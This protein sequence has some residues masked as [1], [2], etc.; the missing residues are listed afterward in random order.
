MQVFGLKRW[1]SLLLA[2]IMIFSVLPF[3]ALAEEEHDH[4]HSHEEEIQSSEPAVTE[5]EVT[6]PSETPTETEPEVTEPEVTEPEAAAEPSAQA[7]ELVN[8]I[9]AV[10][11]TFGVTADMDDQQIKQAIY[12]QPWSV[13][14]PT[15]SQIAQIEALAEEVPE[16]DKDYV[17]ANADV[18]TYVRFAEI[19]KPMFVVMKAS[20]AGDHTPVTGVTVGVSGA[21]DNSMSNGAVTVTAKGS[22][23]ILGFGASAKTATITV[24]NESG[25]TAKISFDW[26]ATSV[27]QLKIDGTVYSG[28]TSGKFEKT[29]DAGEKFIITIT[30]AKNSTVNKLVMSNFVCQIAKDSSSVT[31]QYDNT[32]GSITVAGNAVASGDSLDISSAGAAVVATP[33]NGAAFLGWIDGNHT[34][35]SKD[36]TFTLQPTE[37]MT[38][39]AV[40]AKNAWFLVNGNTLYE[41]LD[42]A[43][44]AVASVSNKTIV[45]ANNGT[46]PAGDYTIPSGVTLLIP[47]DANNTLYTTVPGKQEEAYAAP[48]VYRTLTMA[49]DAKIVVNGAMSIAAVQCSAGGL[50]SPTGPTGFVQ[51][52][53]G[54]NITVNNGGKLYAWG[55]IQGQGAVTVESGG[56]VYECFQ[57]MDWRGG[58][59]T[60]GMIDN[61]QEVFPFTQYYVQNVEVPMKLKA[62]AIENGYMSV[63]ITLAGIQGSEV[64][65]IGSD[66]MFNI[67]DGYIIKDYDEGTGRL[68][69]DIYGNISVKSLSITMKISVLGA[70]TIN[71]KNYDLPINGNMTITMHSGAVTM[72]QDIALLPGAK[73][74]VES[75]AICTLGEGNKIFVYDY[76]EW[77]TA[78]DPA[79][80]KGPS[81]CGTPDATHINLKYPASAT[82]VVG[83]TDDACVIVNGKADLSAGFAYTTSGGANITSTGSGT[84]K[85][86]PGQETVTYQVKCTGSD[87]KNVE[88]IPI[89]IT[90]A[91][92]K[93]ADGSYTLTEDDT[94]DKLYTYKYVNGEWINDCT[95][96][97]RTEIP[98]VKPTCTTAGKTVGEKCSGCGTVT[99]QQ[100]DIEALGHDEQT[101]E[102]KAPTCT[103]TGWD[104]YVTCSRCD[105]STKVEKAAL[106]HDEVEHDAKAPTCTEIGWEAY[107]TC[108]R[109]DYT[110]YAEKAALGHT[111]GAEAT[112]TTNQVCTVCGAELKAAL[113]HAIVSHEAQAPTCTEVGWEAYVTCSRCDYTTYAEKAALDHDMIVDTG[114]AATCTEPGYQSG[115][116]CSRCDYTEGGGVIAALGHTAGAEAT[117]TAAQICTVCNAELKA[118]LGHDEVEHDAKAPTCTE[119]GWDAYETCSRCDYTTYAEKA[120]LGHDEIKHDAK[121]PTCT[122]IGWDA[123]VT[124]SRCNYTTYAEKAALGHDEIKH[125][126]KAPT[127]TEIGWDAY[128]TCSRCN[129]TTYVEKAALDHAIVSHE[130][131]APTC[132]EVGWDAYEACSRC[133]Y[134]T[135]VEKAALGH[136]EVEH[137][138]QAPTC[139][140]IGWDAYVTCTRCDHT[141]YEEKDALG[142]DEVSHEAQ[143]PTCTEIGWDAYVTCSRCNYTTYVPKAALGHDRVSHAAK[144]AT[145]TEIGWQA[146]VTCS[147]CDFTTYK[148]IKAKGHTAGAEATCTEAQ[149]CTVCGAELNA[150]LG[151]DMIIDEK[152][153]ATCTTPGSQAGAHCSR[154]DYTEGGGVIAA[155]GHTPGAEA[156]CTAAQICTVCNAELKAALGHDKETHN[157]KAPTCEDIGWDAY[158]TCSRCDYST[159]VEKAALGHDEVEHD[160]KA[161]TCTE[162][163]W[164][165]YVT[166]SRCDYSTYAEKAALGHDEVEHDA[167]AP[168]C[169]E[170]GWDAYVTCSRCDYSTY[171]E[172]AALGHDEVGHGAKAPTCTAIGWDAYE[173]CS[174]CDYTTYAEKAALG[175]DEVE[176]EAK[177]PTCTEIGWDAYVTC[178]RCDY[179]T[180]AEKAALQHDEIKHDAKAPTCTEIG[181]DAYV[182][183]SRCDYTTYAEKAALD[184]A[185]VKHEAQAPT[186]TEIGWDAYETCSRC[187]YTTYAEKAALGHDEVEHEAQAP[188]CTAFGWDAYV[189]CTRC[190][191]TTYQTKS[192]LGHDEV[193]VAAQAPTCTEV[194]WDAYEACSRCDYSTKVEKAALGHDRVQ[195]DAKNATCTE[196]G[197]QA[198]VTCTRCDLN[199]YKEIS[200]KGHDKKT[201]E[202]KAPT[203]TE[204]GWDAY[205]T[206]SRCDYS[207]YAEKASLGHDEV[208]HDAKAPTCT[209]IGWESFVTCSRCDYTTYAEKAA[210]GHDEVEHDAKAPTCTEIGWDAYVTCSRC[211]YT[212]YAEKAAL[213]HAIVSHDAKAPTCTEIGWDAYEACSRCDYT[214]YVEK[215]AL[216]HTDGAEATCTTNQVC[217]VCGAELKAALGHDM[218]RDNEVPA[219]CTTPGHQ[220][221]AH[222]SRCDYTEGGGEIPALGHTEVIDKAVAPDCENTGLTEG[223]HC[224]VCEKVL[225]AQEVV[226]ALGHTEVIDKAVA[227]DCENTGLT[228]GKHCSVCE[229]ILV[230]QETVKALGHDEVEHDAKAPT[231]TE[232]GW[233]AYETCSRCDYTTYAEKA[234]LGHDEVEHEA[235]APTC[236]EI[237]WDAYVTCSRCDYTTYAEKAALGHDEVAHEA[238]APTCTEIGWEA[239]VTCSR[240]DYTTY[241]EKTALGHDEVEHD[242]KAPTCTEI[243]WDAY[244]TCSRCDYTTYVAKDAL[245]HDKVSHEAQAPTC[246]EIGWKAYVTCTR[247]N[248]T[249]YIEEAA[250]GHDRVSHDAKNPTCTEIGWQAYVTCSRCDFTTY[251]EIKAKGHTAGAEATCT[252]AQICTV[253]KEELKA[254]LGHDEVEHEAKAPTCTEIGWDAYVTCSR[255]DYSTYA[256]KAALKHDEVEHEAKAPTCTEI[257][258]DAYV[259]CSRCDYST[260]AEKA[261]LGHDEEA[262]NAKAPTCTAIGW[263]AY[264]TC[265]RCDYTTYAEK[266]ALGHDEVEHEAQAPTCTEIGWDAY[267]TCSRCDYTT[268]AEKAALGHD[269]VE[270]DAKAPT[271]TEIGWNAYVTCSRC[272]YSTYAEKAA[273]GHDEVGHGAKAPTCTSIGW[274]AYETC[275]RCDYTTYVEKAALGHD[276]VEHEAKAPTCTE[277]GWDAYV[278]CSRCD[279]STYAEK[280]ALKHDEIK[281]DAKAPTCTEIGWNAYVTCSRCDYTTYAEKAALNHAIVKHEAQAPTCTEIGWDAYETCS[282]CDYTTYAQKAA[283][284]HDEVEHEAQAPTCTAIGWDAYETC[285]RCDYTTYVAK[286]ALGHDKVSHEAQAPTCTAIGWNAYETCSRCDYTTY[287]EK[288]A[289]K[290]DEIKHT[291]KEPTCTE[292]G[293][294]AYVTCSRCDYTTYAEKAALGH[295]EVE[296]E[297]KAPTCTEIGWDAYETCSRCDYTT[298]VEKAAL[299]HDVV[300]H[301]AK[302]PTCTE[303]GWDAYETCSRCDY[304]TYVEKAALGHTEVV[305]KAV[306]PDCENTGLTEG[307]HCSVCEKVLVAQNVVDALGH[308]EVVDKAVAPDCENTGLTE[309]KHCSVCEKVLVAQ[310]VVDALGHTEV[311]DEAVAPTCTETGLTEGKHCSVCE[312]TLVKQDVIDALGHK[313]VASEEEPALCETPGMTAG[314]YCSVCNETLSG[315]VEIPARGHNLIN[316]E[317]KNPTFTSPGWEA[318]EDCLRCAYSTYVEIPALGV[319]SIKDF[320]SFITSLNL[321]EMI[322][323]EYVKENPGKDAAT[324]VIKYIRTGVD[325]YNSGSWGI[326]AGYEDTEFAKYVT[327]M[328]DAINSQFEDPA[329]M[330][331]VT[332]LKDIHNFNLPNGD[333]ADVGHIFG[334]MDITNHN[335][336]SQNH[337]DVAGWAGDLVDLLEFSASGKVSGT[338]EEMVA[339][340]SKNYLLVQPS[341]AGMPSMNQLDMDGDLDAIYIM[342]QL[343]A[344]EY[345]PGRLTEIFTGYFTED[346]DRVQRA[347]FFLRNRL[348][349]IS[350]RNNVREAVYKEYMGNRVISTL[351]GTREFNVDNLDDLRMAVCYAF[352][353]YVCKLAG[354]YVESTE[355]PYYTV[356]SSTFET[357]A[358]GITQEIKK[359]TSAD[360]KQM[361]YYVATADVTRSDVDIFVNY[362]NNDPAA[363]WAMQRV[364]DQA[365]AAQNKYGNPESEHYIP[366]YNVIV[367]TNAAGYNMSTGEPGGLLVMGGVEY[368]AVN[369][370]GFF[371]V[372]KD[373]KPVFGSAADYNNIYRGQLRDGVAGFGTTLVKD[374]KIVGA[375]SGRASRTAIGITKTGKIVLMVFDGRQE[376]WSCGGNYAEIA[377]VM[378]DAGCE[379]AINLDG[380]GSTTYVARLPG[381][382]E[383]Q[384][385][386]RPSDGF[387]RSVATSLFVVSTAPSSTAFDHA[388]LESETDYLTLNTSVQLTAKG[389]SATGNEAELPENLTWS[390]SDERWAT[391]TQDGLFTGLRNGSVEVYLM[392]GETVI[393]S[394]T[395]NI[396]VP[397][398]VYFAKPNIDTV[399]GATVDLSVGA[400][401]EGKNVAI[402]A[403]DVTLTLSNAKAGTIDGFKLTCT[404][405]E[406]V[407][408]KSVVVTATLAADETIQAT[409]N[410]ALYKQGEMSF[411]F[412][413]ATGGDRT[414]AWYREVT[415]ANAEDANSYI[416]INPDEDMVTKY[417]LAIDM[418]Q[419]PIPARL[420]ELTYMLPGS[421]VAGASAWTFLLQLAQRISPMSEIRAQVQFDPD[422][423]VDVSDLTL[424]NEYFILKGI[425]QDE[426]TNTITMILNWKKQT[427][428]INPNT[429][430]PLCI[431]SGIQLTPKDDADWGSRNRLDIVNSGSVSYK[432][433]MRAS[434]LYSF[435]QKPENQKVYGLYAYTNPNDPED[436]GG[437]FQDTYKNFEDSYTL[438][439]ALK[440]GWVNEGD[441][442]AYYVAGSKLTGVQKIEGLFYDF[443]E[444]GLNAG[445]TPYTGLFEMN[446]KIYYAQVGVLKS[447]WITIDEYFYYFSTSDYTARTGVQTVAGHTYT[448]GEDG[449]LLRG[450]FYKTD[451]GVRYFWAGQWIYQRWVE[452]PEGKYWVSS[453]GFVS[454][455]YFPV[456]IDHANTSEWHH[457][458]EETGIHTGIADGFFYYEDELHYC[459]NG[460][461][462]EGA[463]QTENG[464][465]Y[466]AP[467]GKVS[468]NN[469]C[470]VA[471]NKCYGCTLQTG[472]YYSDADGYIVANGFAVANGNT[473]YFNNYVRAKGLTKV[474]EK[475]YFFNAGNG[476]MQ[477]D[478]N[479]WIGANNPYGLEAGTYYFQADG[480]MYVPNPEG[481][482]KI[483]EENGK[484]YFTIDGVK[485]KNGLNEL[486]GEYYYA[487]S[488][489]TLEV[490]GVLYLSS[491]NNLI[492]PGSGYFGFGADGKLVKTGF[493]QGGN[494]YTYY[495]QDLVRVKGFTKVGD[496]YYFFNAGS[497]AMQRDKNLWV[498]GSNPYG[499]AAGTYY[500]QADGTMYVPD[501]NGEKKIIEENGKLYFTI[502]GVKQKNGLNELDGEYYYSHTN[503]TL[504]VNGVLYLSSFN[505]LIAPGAGY[506]AFD[507][508]GK[509]V[510]TGFAQGSNGYTYHYQDLVRTKGF[511]KLGDKYYFFNAGSGAMQRDKNLWIG[512]SNPYGIAAGT[513]YFQAD[514]TMYVPDPNGEK[515]IIEENGKLYFTIDGV[516]QTNGLNELDGEYYYANPNGTLAVNTSVYMS[517][518]NDLIAPGSGYFAFDAEGKL[519]KTGFAQGSNGYTYHYQDL[520]RTKGFTKLGDKYYFFNAGSGAMQCDANLWVS[521]S[522]PYGIAAGTYYFQADGTMYVPDPNGEKKIIEENGKLYFTIDGMKQTNGLNEL[523]GEYYYASV[524]GTLAMNTTVYMSSFNDLIAPGAGYF[525]FDAEGKLVKTGF[526]NAS[527]GYTY[528]YQ[529]LVRSKGFT[530]I[531][532]KYYFF[533]A[534]SGA[535][536]CDANLWVAGGNP[537]GIAAG[538]YYFQADGTMYMPDP[539]G[540]K[541][542]IEENGKLYFT[543]DGM[544]QTNGLNELDGEY[545]YAS[546]NGT[547]AV[548]TTVYMSSFNDLI[549]PGA[550][551]FAFDAEG[552]LVKTGFVKADNGHTYHYQDL[553]RSKGFTKIGDD[554][555]FF[556]AS[557]GAMQCNKSL[558][559]SGSNP[560]GIQSGSYYFGADGRMTT[561]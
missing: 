540:E 438:I 74:I 214:T 175:H 163:G 247:C 518:F 89:S 528:H 478:K 185:I 5:E 220:S 254:A 15:I 311:T 489:G 21:T 127:C 157:A 174:R 362:N 486:D 130:A 290:H 229:E 45:L 132:T 46:L 512:G 298:Y 332:G 333:R 261:A 24:Y 123:Y 112:C 150:A 550:G 406:N 534:G 181:W 53:S 71:S 506:F 348:D 43:V 289:L 502:D 302:A 306:A 546:S 265:S 39:Q 415:N 235:Q 37:D 401:Y 280:A 484:L 234:A 177:A 55:F 514:G 309:G 16:A 67:T 279:Y 179:S 226:D 355:N 441:G 462:V 359:A 17:L 346:L 288:A 414:L 259:T 182:T 142:H 370:E 299:G 560:Y 92:L 267:V 421:D 326:M 378:L 557:S 287:A 189:T 227:P 42:A 25:S 393:G 501:P 11:E 385:I 148:E 434:A 242:A 558:W 511:T 50:S 356:F 448:F 44:S 210:L 33:A 334:T 160:A 555:Y 509:L 90:S 296:H 206:C 156:T 207:T 284:G 211:D 119:V 2:L 432:I 375:G 126:A 171:A 513:Y 131:Q 431:V 400:M 507:A 154:C 335:K 143:D 129:Y 473:Y 464:I 245:G 398:R 420:E 54:S 139:T 98:A 225:V 75:G 454:Y 429:A 250:L 82:T 433:Y 13:Q 80:Q 125:D 427:A 197:W 137:E 341:E 81:F 423:E 88:Y 397:D 104:A 188:T 252:A 363:G 59:N 100:E 369:S 99:V 505:D 115:A 228:E 102:A 140:A 1:V 238:K 492:A 120:A 212:T 91:K 12:A 30:T 262:H 61:R 336:S 327:K 134:S 453:L 390:V 485:Q 194:G 442:Y 467:S 269:E 47:R 353:D 480:S 463:I 525:A 22:G 368:H 456:K 201:V 96:E 257:G 496:E 128:E 233:D 324:L 219:T 113:D 343:Y 58:T 73:M 231:C 258:W 380:G 360:G 384:V 517:S 425:E 443:G 529:N 222:C 350:N 147:R 141:T 191:Y 450:E 28:T 424:I 144:N 412:D 38:V 457:F 275:S 260:Y 383:L 446:S 479:M 35:V 377:Q 94:K 224:S 122:E 504:E 413:Q 294:N 382:E 93:N 365:N 372:T 403:S 469:A 476:V 522:N 344:Q 255:C 301:E 542:I 515:K 544:K 319:P 422:V 447:G 347:D 410:V 84:I 232:I 373:G 399:Y 340:I 556:N 95:H 251:K 277:I 170:I 472:W 151:H 494:G 487:H 508:E 466:S 391:I 314:T 221:G 274:D 474:G 283:L 276:E 297:A 342:D 426:Q 178:S 270:H 243:G 404:A 48:T 519:V 49:K 6:E 357:L 537:Y 203:C 533:N 27:N 381:E 176:H 57:V 445:K 561:N 471:A 14:K 68:K 217:T 521:G 166:C 430:N 118:A 159:Y 40:F 36:A 133:S 161:P 374:G 418:T 101:V 239:Y 196:I 313:E 264:V 72:T 248:Y 172:K 379:F 76:D 199:T 551:Y 465:I 105:Y 285:S 187:D 409:A 330:I 152:V 60:S 435:S 452:L 282:R 124:C 386:N 351:E 218:V 477:R 244:E 186:C 491:F 524:N 526:V 407:G 97:T 155:L 545:Y 338:V 361:V 215:T 190:D 192:A 70:K 117:C 109:C 439:N 153:P 444:N 278:T 107:V 213:D 394:K 364:L 8:H 523:D 315:R 411:D 539:N 111:A 304:T 209:E 371:G 408:I 436:R 77:V 451:E 552:K 527:N 481:G 253:C 559:V 458:D 20:A 366:N 19:F 417:T 65:F 532:D 490:N 475:Y 459:D 87:N 483:I 460:L 249:T 325:R 449:K 321:L 503:G 345:E 308:T 437:Y 293:W 79:Q 339:E 223:K 198:Y 312:E 4:D 272:D 41:G 352:A 51:M 246:T 34:I 300:E 358:P 510:K 376:P 419:I 307:K 468:V 428:A 7:V 318:Y 18:Q 281:H 146:Y 106:G 202:A 23:G 531:G 495:Y 286:N 31:F 173:T 292:I 114:K 169:T 530:K 303:I 86:N 9:N 305:D 63:N 62:G 549:A 520:V 200:A 354:D 237:G 392:S 337:A 316:Y 85:L 110:T 500:F 388:V 204:I 180:Y 167:K 78:E 266:A 538:T 554:Y 395:M 236:T 367:S 184:H 230:K 69:I 56:A 317:A 455:G 208:E 216:G 138:A 402:N 349:G 535:M 240:C 488:N 553:V 256:E 323:G 241:V 271:C 164:D 273:L 328:E 295:A 541:K 291:A 158:E 263:D 121:A 387:Q 116:H 103:E 26:T 310:E 516:K 64:P 396:V 497:G 536:Q 195:H 331:C 547:L 461:S 183:C 329:D 145:C 32:L 405:N 416:V 149:T 498:A 548:N 322:A 499:I 543:V 83:R 3:E 136:D 52:N 66:G 162:I 470:Y 108:S 168:T 193:S 10:L 482:K 320:D 440:E 389:I 135:K 205:E 165:A 268:Y 493:V 29:M